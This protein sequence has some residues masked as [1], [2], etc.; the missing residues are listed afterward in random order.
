MTGNWLTKSSRGFNLL[1]DLRRPELQHAIVIEI[2]ERSFDEKNIPDEELITSV[3]PGLVV[4]DPVG[5]TFIPVH[6]T[7][8]E[9]AERFHDTKFRT[10]RNRVV[11]QCLTYLSYDAFCIPDNDSDDIPDVLL[12]PCDS[13][14]FYVYAATYWLDHIMGLSAIEEIDELFAEFLSRQTNLSLAL[15]TGARIMAYPFPGGSTGLQIASALGRLDLVDT[16]IKGGADVGGKNLEGTTSLHFATR[17]ARDSIARLLLKNNAK[18][19]AVS[20]YGEIPLHFAIKNGS[21]SMARILQ[22]VPIS[23]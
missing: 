7:T 23:F 5:D 22:I 4:A 15:K 8:Q 11:E 21:A 14:P 13:H 18:V 12:N 10:E 2:S 3:C 1:R 19:G 9:Y 20:Q 6:Y 16:F 17:N